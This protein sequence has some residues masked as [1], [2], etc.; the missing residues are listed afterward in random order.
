MRDELKKELIHSGIKLDRYG[1]VALSGGNLSARADDGSII[2]TPSGMDYDSLC[3]DDMVVLDLDGKVIEGRR[4]PSVDTVALL[5][6]YKNLSEVNAII[7]THQI[8]ATAVGL[9]EERLPVI[10]TFLANTTLGDVMV[11]PYSSAASEDMG[12]QVVKHLEGKR[13]V[14]LRN[15]GVVT[16]G[17]NIREALY[18]AIYL[19]DAAKCYVAART[20]GTPIELNAEQVR[21]AVKV[22]QNYGQ[23]RIG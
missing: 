12:M 2:V 3:A 4:R 9:V 18:A 11:A 13:A 21:Q 17:K 14:I 19:E 7:H 22:F 8:Y 16:V 23:P 1:L 6:I 10:T 15:H 20:I 5:H